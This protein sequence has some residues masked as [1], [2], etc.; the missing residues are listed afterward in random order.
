MGVLGLTT[1]VAMARQRAHRLRLSHS[2]MQQAKARRSAS[3]RGLAA[4]E[5]GDA[6]ALEE[7]FP[8]L[9]RPAFIGAARQPQDAGFVTRQEIEPAGG[10]GAGASSTRSLPSIARRMPT[11][12]TALRASAALMAEPSSPAY[13]F[14]PARIGARHLRPRH[15]Q[16]SGHRFGSW[17]LCRKPCAAKKG[18]GTLTGSTSKSSS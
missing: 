12:H 18:A 9:S 5:L 15:P 13:R 10:G 3:G 4:I 11:A 14:F 8:V 2:T 7:D 17:N 1:A 16:W 6:R